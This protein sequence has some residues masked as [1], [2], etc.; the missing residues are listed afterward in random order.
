MIWVLIL[1]LHR[2]IVSSM[3]SKPYNHIILLHAKEGIN[4]KTDKECKQHKNQ[5]YAK[6]NK[7]IL[8]ARSTKSKSNTLQVL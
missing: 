4:A 6:I 5:K 7:N 8:H 3:V 1:F 2:R